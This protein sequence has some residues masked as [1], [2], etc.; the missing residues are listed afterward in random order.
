MNYLRSIEKC[1]LERQ[2]AQFIYTLCKKK[3]YI[4]SRM[5]ECCQGT[6]LRFMAS[7]ERMY[8]SRDKVSIV[9]RQFSEFNEDFF[10]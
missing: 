9:D 3:I 2:H 4:S 7:L 5:S 10:Q 6:R 8:D 1:R